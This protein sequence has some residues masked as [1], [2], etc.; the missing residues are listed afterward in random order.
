M[1]VEET[2]VS[3]PLQFDARF[4]EKIL[5]EHVHV[6]VRYDAEAHVAHGVLGEVVSLEMHVGG[7]ESSECAPMVLPYE[8][9]EFALL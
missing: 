9:R 3:F 8:F 4:H 2:L 6:V 7:T 1:L 5:F